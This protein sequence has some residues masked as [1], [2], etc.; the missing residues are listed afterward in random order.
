MNISVIFSAEVKT[1]Y[2]KFRECFKI[3]MY[4]T[5][6]FAFTEKSVKLLELW[7][8]FVEEDGRRRG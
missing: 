2:L 3:L 7:T 1:I 8:E 4:I 6:T 5:D